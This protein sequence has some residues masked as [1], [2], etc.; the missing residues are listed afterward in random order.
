MTW[1]P[2]FAVPATRAALS[3]GTAS[4]AMV[5]AYTSAWALALSL[6]GHTFA[7][8]GHGSALASTLVVAAIS[9]LAAARRQRGEATLR[10]ISLVAEVAQAT[11][12][13]PIPAPLGGLTFATM[14][15][16]AAE[17]ARIGSHAHP[18]PAHA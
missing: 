2:R 1:V 12:V 3:V 17:E 5:A 8:P 11:I 15:R 14:Y 9:I 13:R 6:R 7:S 4:T 18:A 16:S 10:Q